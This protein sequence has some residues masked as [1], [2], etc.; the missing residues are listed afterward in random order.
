MGWN[1]PLVLNFQTIRDIVN[2]KNTSSLNTKA[3]KL[4]FLRILGDLPYSQVILDDISEVLKSQNGQAD[5]SQKVQPNFKDKKVS[6]A[7]NIQSNFQAINL[8]VIK[9]ILCK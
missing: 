3:K 1:N 9:E 2:L 5:K 6:S 8:D 4:D 7:Y